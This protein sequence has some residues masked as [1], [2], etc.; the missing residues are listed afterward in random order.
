[1]TSQNENCLP[2]TRTREAKAQKQFSLPL[3]RF[4]CLHHLK[5][6]LVIWLLSYKQSY[7]FA[8]Y[9][10][11]KDECGARHHREA[12]NVFI[13]LLRFSS[14]FARKMTFLWNARTRKPASFFCERDS[15]FDNKRN[16]K[17]QVK[18]SRFFDSAIRAYRLEWF[19]SSFFPFFQ[20][21]R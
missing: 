18:S 12:L 8:F 7:K 1:M 21:K 3:R 20:P 19:S 2:Q 16:Q 17:Q 15:T 9:I 14:F 11:D 10:C 6:H 13:S 4:L 5:S